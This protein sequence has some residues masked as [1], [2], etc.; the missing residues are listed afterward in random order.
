MVVFYFFAF[1]RGRVGVV[2]VVEGFLCLAFSGVAFGCL[3]SS[4]GIRRR[5]RSASFTWGF[6]CRARGGFVYAVFAVVA[7]E[8]RR[9]DLGLVGSCAGVTRGLGDSFS[10]L[11]TEVIRDFSLRRFLRLRFVFLGIKNRDGDFYFCIF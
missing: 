2:A 8:R 10:R 1:I 9:G 5:G 6:G 7:C 4:S 11:G 3:F